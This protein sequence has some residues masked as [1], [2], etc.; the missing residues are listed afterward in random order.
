M[1]FRDTDRIKSLDI[2]ENDIGS[3]N[4]TIL[5]PIFESNT[6]IEDLNIADCQLDGNCVQKLCG[7]L[8]TINQSL[9]VLKFRNSSLGE[10]G[11]NAIA[12]LIG[13]N[14]TLSELE[15]FNCDIDEKGGN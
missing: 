8:K 9:R 10:V 1:A 13:G 15:I 3:R 6:C 5:L 7:I 4:F 14:M 12:D 11:A 2:S